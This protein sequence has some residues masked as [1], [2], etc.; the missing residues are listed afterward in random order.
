MKNTRTF[1]FRL[2][3]TLFALFVFV[4]QGVIGAV[5]PVHAVPAPEQ[6]SDGAG[7]DGGQDDQQ[8][9][10]DKDSG[11]SDLGDKKPLPE[12]FS[13]CAAAGGSID[14]LLLV[15]ESG[16]LN[17]TDPNN[18]RVTSGLHLVSRMSKLTKSGNLS[19]A[20]SGFG[21]TY[22]KVRDWEEIKDD[23]D[24]QDLRGAINELSNRTDGIDTD[25]WTAMDEARKQL[26]SRAHERGS[27]AKSCQAII[28]F[29]DGE[30]DYEVR[31][32]DA[33]SKYGDTKP[34]A[35][36]ISLKTDDGAK[37]VEEKAREDI[38]RPGGLA[39]QLRSSRVAMFGVG[40]GS[41]DGKEFDLMRSI[42]TGKDSSG[43]TCGDLT[44]PV[45]GEF[46]LAS[47]IDSLLFAFDSISGLGQKPVTGSHGV[48]VKDFCRDESHTF[49]LDTTTRDVDG[50]ATATADGLRAALQGPDGKVV[51]LTN[52][53]K[54]KKIEVSGVPVTYTWES[55]RSLSFRLDG[56]SK[57]K[58]GDKG[59]WV[60]VWHLAFIADAD[61]DSQAK[62]KSNLHITPGIVP[63]WPDKDKAD[64]RAGS[65]LKGVTFTLNDRQGNDVAVD[66]ITSTGKFT[67]TFTD[68]AGQETKLA[69]TDTFADIS[70]P[71][72]WDLS[73]VATGSGTLNLAL[74][75]TTASAKDAS[76]KTV[77]GTKLSPATVAIPV[78]VEPPLDYPTV[79]SKVDFGEAKG[80]IDLNTA[81]K[82]GGKGCAWVEPDSTKVI[83][84]PKE[85][86][87]V[88]V[89]SDASGQDNCVKAGQD[90]GVKLASDQQ[91]NGAINGT[92]V[93][94]TTAE[95]G[96]GEPIKTKVEFTASA[97]KP[98]NAFNFVTT[99]IIALLLGPGIPLLILYAIKWWGAKIPPQ[100]LVAVRA[101]IEKTSTGVTRDG[102]RFAF[103]QGDMRNTVMIESGGSR[104]I[105][106]AGVTLKTKMGG[107]PLGSG[108]VVVDVPMS[109]SKHDPAR[110]P[111][112]LPL[113][114]HNHW[115]VMRTEA[116]DE[117]QAEI[118]VLLAGNSDEKQ[119]KKMEDEIVNEAGD[120]M[121]RLPSAGGQ[122][123]AGNDSPF[124]GP[125]EPQPNP[126][127]EAGA[128]SQAPSGN[129]FGGP[130]SG[131]AGPGGPGSGPSMPGP[132][133]PG[134]GP[135]GPNPFGGGP[136][137]PGPGNGPGGPGSGPSFP[138]PGGP[139]SGPGG[140]N[141]FGGPGGPGPGGPNQPGPGHPGPG[142]PGPGG[143]GQSGPG[144][145]GPGQTSPGQPGQNPFNFGQ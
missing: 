64:V 45:P 73:N 43:K 52:G 139:G 113:A 59:P 1:V 70:K 107:S 48:C 130:G 98:L 37:K 26:A 128:P 133:G 20:V 78:K 67:A 9:T 92:F 101:R 57:G 16:S 100:P 124:G 96:Q 54:D 49:V 131:P 94:V 111:A 137:M 110:V 141:P 44:D 138:G 14:V 143:P 33:A 77:K 127:A 76:G 95:N 36:D 75:L 42:A 28:W 63:A 120:L 53:A 11:G 66:K 89:T 134:S 31:K 10:G 119:R 93:V 109:V 21:H 50:F 79:P 81:L 114:V 145:P 106:A 7:K 19:V 41:K 142:G 29:S 108:Y 112:R 35:P 17:N 132:G 85:L 88:Q 12:Q 56:T 68:S 47:D 84:S 69:S 117:N 18:A 30:L 144:H 65:T 123:S 61:K 103:N 72:D 87:N 3:V 140:P 51:E 2:L 8:D 13:A 60:G 115:L 102:V 136:N 91:G 34:F 126:F 23:G 15:D 32:G 46:Y 38:C 58:I 99:L 121:D 24:I 80:N 83:A 4:G 39:D 104:Q 62:S 135:G 129:P 125:S 5:N 118:L 55:D 25:Y 90:L 27:D 6:P 116:M 105:D 86:K 122:T 97:V 74:E 22:S 71:F 40:L 82:L